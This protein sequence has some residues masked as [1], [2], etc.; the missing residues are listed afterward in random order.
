MTHCQS[1][2]Q[3][4]AV[5]SMGDLQVN[6][7][8]AF[9]RCL[10]TGSPVQQTDEAVLMTWS[11]GHVA[12]RI[13][14]RVISPRP[15]LIPKTESLITRAIYHKPER[16]NESLVGSRG[17]RQQQ[18]QTF[19]AVFG[20]ISILGL[21]EPTFTRHTRLSPSYPPNPDDPQLKS[22]RARLLPPK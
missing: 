2:S 9:M 13:V 19:T 4:D 11:F 1:G 20:T 7:Y 8:G 22:T 21:I 5:L 14:H 16:K 17:R 3:K 6:V 10:A 12:G 15:P 18:G